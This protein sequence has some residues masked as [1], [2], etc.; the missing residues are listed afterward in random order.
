MNKKAVIIILGVVL[1]AVF[2]YLSLKGGGGHTTK[3]QAAGTE[4]HDIEEKVSASGRIQPKTKVDITSEINGEIILLPVREGQ[5]V[6]IGDLLVVLDTVQISSDVNQARFGNDEIRARLDGAKTTLEQN[7]EEYQRQERLF[8]KDLT[9]ETAYKNAKYA[10]LN[11]KA[12]YE[13]MEASAR[14]S[15]SR[16]AKQLDYLSKAK[17]SAPMS[18]VITYLD[19]EVGEI[20]A[21]QTSFT[22]GRTIMTIADLSIFEVEV[23]VDETEINKINIGQ[24][25]E[26]EVD[27]IPDTAFAGKVVEI[28]NTAIMAGLGTQDQSTNF[29]VKVTFTEPNQRLRPGMSATVDI[30]TNERKDVLAIPFAS[31]VMRK[32]DLDSLEQ[33]RAEETSGPASSNEVMAAEGDD[34]S[35][36]DSARKTDEKEREE[37]KGV[38]VVRDGIACFVQVETGVADQKNIEVTL[39]IEEGDKVVSGPYKALRTIKDGDAV[40][41]TEKSSGGDSN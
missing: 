9:S 41:I 13:A 7:E 22:Q 30:T 37:L 38:F 21:A 34:E 14:Q 24:S 8:A 28:G 32:Y 2:G 19:A 4:R 11:S 16:Y 23:E 1:I 6:T 31:I 5:R 17:I 35:A 20:A 3:V 40:E 18:G 26:I 12:A 10:Y 15:E 33:A 25:A 36:T 39:G 29:K 27:A